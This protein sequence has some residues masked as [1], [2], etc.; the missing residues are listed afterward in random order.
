MSTCE[1]VEGKANDF[2]VDFGVWNIDGMRL[3]ENPF[4]KKMKLKKKKRKD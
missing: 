1:E 3:F 2:C 4:E